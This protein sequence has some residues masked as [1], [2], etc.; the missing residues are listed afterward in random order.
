MEKHTV[1][2]NKKRLAET[3]DKLTEENRQ[4]F[5]SVLEALAFAQKEQGKTG[6]EQGAY[7]A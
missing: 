4:C 2:E 1:E 3:V 7:P 5:L 6:T